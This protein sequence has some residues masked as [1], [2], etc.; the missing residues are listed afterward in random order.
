MWEAKEHTYIPL[1]Y[2]AVAAMMTR[3]QSMNEKLGPE[4]VGCV[5]AAAAAPDGDVVV[6]VVAGVA[7]AA[8]GAWTPF[9]LRLCSCMQACARRRDFSDL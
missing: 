6:V 5:V 3:H 2:L 9:C 1:A 4:A 7:A 8:A